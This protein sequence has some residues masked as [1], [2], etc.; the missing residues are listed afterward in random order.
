MVERTNRKIL[1]VLRPIVNELGNWEDW[2]PHVA[3][4]LNSS[5][6]DSTGKSPHYI[7]FGVEKR[8]PYD[9][10]TGPQQP[11]CNT[12]NYTQQ[13][14]HVLGK[15]HSSVRSKLKAIKR[16]IPVNFK[17][18]DTV[19]IQQPERK[20]KLSLKFLSPYKIVRYVYGNKFA[21]MELNTNITLVI[22]SDRLKKIPSPSDS[23]LAADGVPVEQADTRREQVTQ[24]DSHTYNLRPR[25]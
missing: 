11:V 3:A 4:S 17:Q 9:L 24:Q 15:T 2:L 22:H 6:N 13:Q 5:I 18:G 7:F 16:A 10:L 21:L 19:M 14:L 1:E 8:L 25:H 20:S 12:D 23:P